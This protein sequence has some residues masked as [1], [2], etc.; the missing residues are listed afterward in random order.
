MGAANQ[1]LAGTGCQEK[2]V[3]LEP[4]HVIH[5]KRIQVLFQYNKKTNVYSKSADGLI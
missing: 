2:H 1:E 4:Q 5:V 3:T